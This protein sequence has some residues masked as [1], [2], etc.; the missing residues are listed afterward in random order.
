MR[1]EEL[2]K[3]WETRSAR[4]ESFWKE[5]GRLLACGAAF[6]PGVFLGMQ[7]VAEEWERAERS[8]VLK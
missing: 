7:I 4:T 8:G 6:T 2:V 3:K 5:M 1:D